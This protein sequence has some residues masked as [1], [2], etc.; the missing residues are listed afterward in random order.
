MKRSLVFALLLSI[1]HAPVAMAGRGPHD[2]DVASWGGFELSCTT[3]GIIRA[4]RGWAETQPA[5]PRSG[6]AR[7]NS[8]DAVGVTAASSPPVSR[9]QPQG[10]RSC[11]VRG[12]GL[13]AAS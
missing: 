3:S 4:N 12:Y 13:R 9:I 8:R 6:T 1:G 2:A 10:L 11:G 7:V 5:F